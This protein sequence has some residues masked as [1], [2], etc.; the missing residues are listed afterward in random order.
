M[1]RE[2]VRTGRTRTAVLAL[3]AAGAAL[4]AAACS[5]SGSSA[6]AGTDGAKLYSINCASCHGADGGGG[7]GPSMAEVKTVFPNEADHIE[8]VKTKAATTSGPYGAGDSGNAGKG[9]TPG[10]MPKY[11]G[12]LSDEQNKAVVTYEREELAAK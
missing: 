3:L 6:D 8:W 2:P 7:T 12:T 10:A 5:S 1:R 11:E 9:A 4:V